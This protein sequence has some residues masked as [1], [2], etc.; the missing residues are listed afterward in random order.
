MCSRSGCFDAAKL[1]EQADQLA[2]AS[3]VFRSPLDVA[4]R[5]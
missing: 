3:G 4:P 5:K 2:D 1:N